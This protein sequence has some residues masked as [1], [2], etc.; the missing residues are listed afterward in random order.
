[1]INNRWLSITCSRNDGDM[2]EAFIRGNS[3]FIDKFVI[4]DD[5]TDN[6]PQILELLTREGYDIEVIRRPGLV[7]SQREKTN[8]MF[9]KY[10]KP[11]RF[12]AVIPLDVDEILVANQ[13]GITKSDLENVNEAKFLPW[14]PYAPKTQGWT[15][16]TE[17]LQ[18][19][20]VGTSNQLDTIRKVFIPAQSVSKSGLV[21]IG[22]HSYLLAGQPAVRGDHEVLSIAHFPVRTWEQIMSKVVTQL[23][24]V[25]IK[26]DKLKGE[27]THLQGLARYLNAASN[28]KDLLSLQTIAAYYAAFTPGLGKNLEKIQFND[29]GKLLPNIS[30]SYLDYAKVNLE[31]NM[32]KIID[33]LIELIMAAQ[34][35]TAKEDK[36]YKFM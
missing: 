32:L 25:R 33:E 19:C 29:L 31:A 1:M 7:A 4:M 18:E 24:A 20:F 34:G 23:T 27:S 8:F 3:A 6:T 15:S 5:S 14:I 17:S 16:A 28:S 13:K 22:A 21:E 10:A 12:A 35:I 11:K 30:L 36:P 26:K 2:V 9:Q